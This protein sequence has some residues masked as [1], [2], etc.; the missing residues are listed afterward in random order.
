MKGNNWPVTFS[1]GLATFN[2]PPNSVDDM[3]KA[4]DSLMCKAENNRKNRVKY[5]TISPD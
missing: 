3:I 5:S 2:K 4:A 1:I